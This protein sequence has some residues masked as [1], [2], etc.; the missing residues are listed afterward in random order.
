MGILSVLSFLSILVF[1]MSLPSSYECILMPALSCPSDLQ[2]ELLGGSPVTVLTTLL[3]VFR[4]LTFL[5][6]ASPVAT[7]EKGAS[8]PCV[9][10]E[11]ALHLFLPPL[12]GGLSSPEGELLCVCSSSWS[13]SHPG[14]GLFQSQGTTKMGPS[15]SALRMLSWW[16]R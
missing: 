12:W 9:Q 11:W 15:E 8:G 2:H 14:S 4:N 7:W 13:A 10:T 16:F 5:L 3:S 6:P 1:P